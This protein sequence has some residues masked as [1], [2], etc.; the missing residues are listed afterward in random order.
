MNIDDGD[1][2]CPLVHCIANYEKDNEGMLFRKHDTQQGSY[3]PVI[4]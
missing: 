3:Y 4:F 2:Q 1:A